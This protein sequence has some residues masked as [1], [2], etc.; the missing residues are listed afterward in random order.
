M[1]QSTGVGRGGAR[2]NS[3][4]PRRNAGRPRGSRTKVYKPHLEKLV[5]A[6][7]PSPK[8]ILLDVMRRHYRARR[9]DEAARV[10]SLV[11]PYIHPRLSCASV[12]VT[13]RSVAQQLIEM[14]DEELQA[15]IAELK[16]MLCI[17]F[18]RLATHS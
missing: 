5:A 9:Y 13:P 15:H 17:G 12:A 4:G 18:R 11:A 1:T 3:G 7:G 16:E 8:D 6:G 14:T 2:A 10:A